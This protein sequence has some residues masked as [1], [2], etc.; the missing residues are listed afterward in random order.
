MIIS[1]LAVTALGI[2]AWMGSLMG[3]QYVLAVCLPYTAVIV[4]L[5][6]FAW[7][8]ID[9]AKRPVPFSIPTTGGQQ[10]SLP[11][12]KPATLDNPSDKK[13][14]WGRMI[15]E[16]LL[17]RSLFRNTNVSIEG[18]R[19]VYW[20]S[21][22]LWLFALIFHYC[23]LIIFV[24]HFRFFLEPVPFFVNGIEMLDGIMQI[25]APRLFMTS[26]LIMVALLYLIGRRLF[27]QKVRYISLLSDYF[28]L[29]L[30]L[31][32]CA[33]GIAMRYFMKVDIATVKV[34][35][36]SLLHF[37]PDTAAL[38]KIGSIFY[39]HMFFLAV[40]LMYFP[41]SKLMHAGGVFLSP[42]RNLAND[43][44]IKLH[45]NPW[46]PEKEYRTYAEYEDE[47]RVPMVEAGLRVDKQPEE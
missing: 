37:A 39:V 42:T 24:R 33:T 1:L 16:V 19:V 13:G 2:L 18:D 8:I 26:P 11:W 7:R 29:F 30:I 9:W 23:F 20:S 32:L 14:V 15:L 35:V 10:K 41:F 12:I 38:A 28:P 21:K 40:L 17:F 4:F 31:G 22:F 3:F 5:V 45:V 46:N 47:F 36:I 27:N 25:G 43:S 44:R 34:F 6:G